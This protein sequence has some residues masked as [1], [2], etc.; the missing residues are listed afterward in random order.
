LKSAKKID[1]ISF[2]GVR[3]SLLACDRAAR[4]NNAHKVDLVAS[5][6]GRAV[7]YRYSCVGSV[8]AA[9]GI[10]L[11]TVTRQ[12]DEYLIVQAKHAISRFNPLE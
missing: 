5:S 11:L 12:A 2:H 9:D 1:K 4:E 10:N 6:L 7:R 3:N 8:L